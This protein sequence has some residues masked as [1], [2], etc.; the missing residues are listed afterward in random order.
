MQTK[1]KS[2]AHME[3]LT[4]ALHKIEELEDKL[5]NS[6]QGQSYEPIAILGMGCRFPGGV[7]TPEQFWQ[8]VEGKKNAIGKVPKTR[9][10]A[11]AFYDSDPD[12]IGKVYSSYG[13]FLDDVDQFDASFF[14]I[15]PREAQ[16]MDPQQRIALET[17]W[18]ALEQAGQTKEGVKGKE[19]AVFM[20]VCGNDYITRS[21]HSGDPEAINVHSGTGTAFSVVSGRI[22]YQLGLQGPSVTLDTACSSS[23]VA[24]HLACRAIQNGDAS[25]AV[26]GG[27]NLI[28]DPSTH[29]YFSRIRA[30]ATDG[31]CKTFDASADG[32]VRSEGCGVIVLKKLSE[33]LRDKDQV[34]GVLYG[35]AVN[36]DGNSN[37]LTAPNGPSQVSVIQ[38]A[39]AN[40]EIS[41]QSIDFVETHGTGTPLGDTIEAQALGKVFQSNRS[42]DRPLILGAVKTNIG[43]TEAAAGVAGVIK[44]VLAL[45]KGVIPPNLNFNNPS[46]KIPWSTLPL[47]VPE[48]ELHWPHSAEP[49]YAGVSGFGFSGTNTHLIIGDLGLPDKSADSHSIDKKHTLP[50]QPQLLPIS[51]HTEKSLEAQAKAYSEYLFRSESALNDIVASAAMRRTHY[52]HRIAVVGSTKEEAIAALSNYVQTGRDTLLVK[53]KISERHRQRLV[54]VFSGQGSDW[55][56]MGRQLLIEQPVF[57]ATMEACDREIRRMTDWSLLD[58][59]HAHESDPRLSKIEIIQ[60]ITFAMQVSLADLYKSWGVEPTTVVGQSMG[61]VAAAY[62]A[63]ALSLSQSVQ[64]I[65]ERTRML[66]S[67]QEGSMAIIEASPA[68]VETLIRPFDGAVTI[69]AINSSRMS[70]VSGPAE[71]LDALIESY[72]GYAKRV[73]TNRAGHSPACEAPSKELESI[74]HNLTPTS[75]KIK[76]MSTVTGGFVEGSELDAKYWRKNMREPVVFSKSIQALLEQEHTLFVEVSPHPISGSFIEDMAAENRELQVTFVPSLLRQKDETAQLMLSLGKLYCNGYQLDWSQIIAEGKTCSILPPYSWDRQRYWLKRPEKITQTF[77]QTSHP[78]L[79]DFFTSS[80]SDARYMDGSLSVSLVPI[81]SDHQIQNSIVYPAAGYLEMALHACITNNTSTAGCRLLE[82][83]FKQFLAF[84]EDDDN[85]IDLQVCIQGKNEG[86]QTLS[87]SSQLNGTWTRHCQAIVQ[88]SDRLVTV[89]PLP[90]D[91][92]VG[93]GRM[94]KS[95]TSAEHYARLD[96]LGLNYGAAF[97]TVRELYVGDSEALGLLG[98]NSNKK[99][100]GG[101][102]IDPCLVDGA[103]QVLATA[104]LST[105]G[106]EEDR[107]FVP[108]S[109][110]EVRFISGVERMAWC[111]ALMSPAD[112]NVDTRVGDVRIYDDNGNL[113]VEMIGFCVKPI[114]AEKSTQEDPILVLQW[115]ELESQQLVE[116]SSKKWLILLDQGGVGTR[117]SQYLQSLGHEVV[118]IT[119]RQGEESPNKEAFE[120]ILV[121]AFS[122]RSPYGVIHLWSLDLNNEEPKPREAIP[123]DSGCGTALSLVQALAQA[124]WRDPAQLWLVTSGA[125]SVSADCEISL[126]QTPLIGLGRTIANEYPEMRCTRIDLDPETITT[127]TGEKLAELFLRGDDEEE[128]ALRASR[129]YGSRITRGATATKSSEILVPAAEDHFGLMIDEAGSFDDLRL[130]KTAPKTLAATE[131]EIKVHTAGMNFRDVLTALGLVSLEAGAGPSKNFQLGG[132]FCGVVT[133]IGTAVQNIEVGQKVLGFGADAFGSH[134]IA[135]EH[136]VTMM[137]EGMNE[138]SAASISIAH[139]T[140]FYSLKYLARLA[141]GER[142]LIH[143]A[144]G[145]V[146]LAAI[147]WAQHVGAEIFA[148]AGTQEKRDYLLSL[149]VQCVGDSRSLDFVEDVRNWTSGEGVDVVLNS[150]S[151]A[152]IE[153]SFKLLKPYGRFIEIGKLDYFD[154]SQLGLRPFLRNLTFSLFDLA[155]MVRERPEHVKALFLEII[156]LLEQGVLRPLPCQSFPISRAVEAFRFMAEGRHTGKVV[157]TMDEPELQVSVPL[158]DG[159]SCDPGACYLITG[160]L[161]ALGLSVAAWLVEQGA[162]QLVLLGRSGATQDDQKAKVEALRQAGARVLVEKVDISNAPEVEKCFASFRSTLGP[163]KGVIHAA[164]VLDDGTIDQQTSERFYQ[165]W[166]A[167]IN[168]AWNLHTNTLQDPLDFFILYSSASAIFGPPGQSNYASA[169]TFL[170]SLAH[171]RKNNGKCALSINWGAFSDVGLAATPERAERLSYRGM[172]S[173]NTDEA[174]GILGRLLF[175]NRAQIGVAPVDIR[176]WVEFYPHSASSSMLAE[177]LVEKVDIGQR[178]GQSLEIELLGTPAEPRLKLL[179]KFVRKQLSAIVRI[180]ESQIQMSAPFKRLGID[181]L[182]ALELRN[183]LEA[184]LGLRLSATLVWTYPNINALASYLNGLLR[185]S[186]KPTEQEEAISSL[187]VKDSTTTELSDDE[188]VSLGRTLLQ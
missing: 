8:L 156:E 16:S 43:H 131:L 21:M 6:E 39:L 97:Q 136:Q 102:Q 69:S 3:L 48:E 68:E 51:A 174:L 149:G 110:Q 13:G 127:I 117:L 147:Q 167:K 176:Q 14:D 11:D 5:D 94:S 100:V 66:E 65:C 144:A 7:R 93:R 134:A 71:S 153:E 129:V 115:R 160:G 175:D 10:D 151:G 183:R 31:Q 163:L 98:I 101:Y 103:F 162:R 154:N 81:L 184:G 2:D 24:I 158:E 186:A 171:F 123:L 121:E 139:L 132:E 15:S 30:L 159:V 46:P 125:Q 61:E 173:L 84:P 170:D 91:F 77:M 85:V 135:T 19:I 79:R 137:P 146:G 41:P 9:W 55:F 87:I 82:V 120:R 45:N 88:P 166:Q 119:R 56:G 179:C 157:L 92:T 86:K 60:P 177:L 25:M 64:I 130:K 57:R 141:R 12:M 161:G 165:V 104:M 53:G 36:Q 58:V 108:I 83:E 35:S 106:D 59:L 112:D 152:A 164:V 182:M 22:S 32:M 40:A 27:I 187:P 105:T 78:F 188:L 28:L 62:C 107:P 169:N 143:A 89:E 80:V 44:T 76:F 142:V 111:H 18:E 70:A 49:R 95:V 150:L 118:S 33:A 116:L 47:K 113:L 168:G 90:F 185:N 145:G 42:H 34:L 37:G 114:E 126:S 124:P 99:Q 20:G 52:A 178:K 72:D 29:L 50:P 140:A 180:E 17:T 128:L 38:Q 109:I 73:R 54:F 4:K 138:E 74:L 1:N 63:G 122:E 75:G 172:A 133:R 23:S 67:M 26:A 155:G 181:S 148:T 96:Q